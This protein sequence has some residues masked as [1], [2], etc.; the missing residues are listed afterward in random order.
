MIVNFKLFILTILLLVLHS[1]SEDAAS[2]RLLLYKYS[3][4]VPVVEGKSFV[5]NYLVVN[6]GEASAIGIEIQDKYNANS[7]DPDVNIDGDGNVFFKIEEIAPGGQY[8][9]NV[10]VKPKLYGIYE[11]TRAR[12]KYRS[13]GEVEIEG[14]ETEFKNG[15]STSLGRIRIISAVEHERSQSYY[16]KEWLAFGLLYSIPTLLPLGLFLTAKGAA[17][18]LSTKRKST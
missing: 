8:M 11:S 10:T 5:V 7:F 18:N 17:E 6:S 2:S 14:I 9:F 13:E 3:E 4:T 16:V 1:S 12:I 15:F